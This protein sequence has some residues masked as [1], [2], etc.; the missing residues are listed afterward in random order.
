MIFVSEWHPSLSKLPTILKK[1]YHLLQSD[2]N[3]SKV[4]PDP[5]SVAF[6][7]PKSIR[8]HL[9]RGD[10]LPT[11]KELTCTMPCGKNCKIC[12]C[13]SS[14]TEIT[15]PKVKKTIQ[16][17]KDFGT[18]DSR[19]LIYAVRCKKCNVLYVGHTGERLKDRM[20]KHRYDCRKRP[21]N[22]ELSFHFHPNHDPEKDMEIFILQTGLKTVEEREFYEDRWICRLQTLQ[23]TGVNKDIHPYAQAMYKCCKDLA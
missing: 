16:R 21:D 3:L 22:T 6:R 7:R 14:E 5:P 1:H 8:N 23:P 20:S 12:K 4:F 13:L 18:C 15:N 17:I 11:K 19:N 10:I 9:I 2:Q